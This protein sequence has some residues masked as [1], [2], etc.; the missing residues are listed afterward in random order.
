MQI[1]IVAFVILGAIAG[2]MTPGLEPPFGMPDYLVH[3]LTFFICSLAILSLRPD[4][5]K[6][7]LVAML[8]FAIFMEVSQFLVPT[9]APEL[10][11][12]ICNL[13]GVLGAYA[14]YPYIYQ[15]QQIE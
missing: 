12:V 1:T 8:L 6:T 2:M 7:S 9:R 15:K 11:D 3:M 10:T 14:I 13:A 5:Y 4:A